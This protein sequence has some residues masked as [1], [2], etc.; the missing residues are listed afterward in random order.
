MDQQHNR[1]KKEKRKKPTLF[2]CKDKNTK[3]EG[4]C[5]SFRKSFCFKSFLSPPI[6]RQYQHGL[7]TTNVG[8]NRPLKTVPN[9]LHL[10]KK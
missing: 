8:L 1:F 4:L 9:T 7:H 2:I 6:D 5:S 10:S 3:K